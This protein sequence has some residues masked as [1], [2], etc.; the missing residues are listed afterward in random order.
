[1][2]GLTGEKN[3]SLLQARV[4][5][6]GCSAQCAWSELGIATLGSCADDSLLSTLLDAARK[7][8]AATFRAELM[9]FTYGTFFENA[10]MPLIPRPQYYFPQDQT[11]EA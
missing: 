4:K 9:C 10:E 3:V 2:V 7:A 6:T 8:V 1:M 11:W 5:V